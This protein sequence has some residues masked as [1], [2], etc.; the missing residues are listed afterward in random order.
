ML[1]GSFA[2][3]K[4]DVADGLR[5]LRYSID[6]HCRSAVGDPITLPPEEN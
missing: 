4:T 2:P 1:P 5:P 6:C 3:G